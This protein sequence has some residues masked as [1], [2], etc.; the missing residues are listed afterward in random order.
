MAAIDFAGLKL[1]LMS[2]LVA[3]SAVRLLEAFMN[4]EH[5]S[6]TDLAWYVGIHLTF[7]VSSLV[8]ALTERFSSEHDAHPAKPE[9]VQ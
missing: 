3:I 5:E 7:V 4:L 1:K 2:S 9:D 6:K 8:L